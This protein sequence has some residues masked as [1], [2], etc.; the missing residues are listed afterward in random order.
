MALNTKSKTSPPSN[1]NSNS[2]NAINGQDNNSASSSPYG[3]PTNSP[4]AKKVNI[5]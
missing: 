2:P 3:T 4:L 1:S 5:F